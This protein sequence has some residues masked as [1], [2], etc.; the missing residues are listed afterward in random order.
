MILDRLTESAK[1][2]ALHP[3]FAQAFAW[4]R[5]NDLNALAPGKYEL[6]GDRLYALVSDDQGRT[7]AGAKLES[8]RKYIDIQY[9]VR[10][11]ELIGWLPAAEC[12]QV[13][14]AYDASRDL[15]LYGDASETWLVMPAGTF[16]IFWPCDGHA[17]LATDGAVR[18][19][20]LKIA[21]E[22]KR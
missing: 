22:E 11:D 2:E 20:V 12:R 6:S 10:G 14:L 18:K 15:L 7:R 19:V 4:L 3:L 5:A 8:H 1:Y 13:E 16:T 21:V 17:P 9:V